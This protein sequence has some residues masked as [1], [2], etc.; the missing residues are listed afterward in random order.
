MKD[1]TAHQ[2]I[3]A[4]AVENWTIVF[5]PF[6]GAVVVAVAIVAATD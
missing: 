2:R 4:V 1:A 5:L 3:H 6:W